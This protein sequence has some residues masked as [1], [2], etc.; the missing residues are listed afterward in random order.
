MI[1]INEL[2]TGIVIRFREQYKYT[3]NVLTKWGTNA[4]ILWV[5]CDRSDVEVGEIRQSRGL[6]ATGCFYTFGI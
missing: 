5:D 6:I 3:V 2:E 1:H 4:A